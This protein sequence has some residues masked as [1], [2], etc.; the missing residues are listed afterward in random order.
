[1]K[2]HITLLLSLTLL[3][4]EASHAQTATVSGFSSVRRVSFSRPIPRPT[5]PAKLV[6]G[7]VVFSDPDDNR[8]INAGEMGCISFRVS[9]QGTGEAYVI[10]PG[11]V[12]NYS[13]VRLGEAATIASLPP[14]ES[15]VVRVSV[16]S[17]MRLD[18]RKAVFTITAAEGNGFDA[19]RQLLAVGTKSFDPPCVVVADTK[20]ETN[21]GGFS[22]S[23]GSVVRMQVL[24]QNTGLSAARGVELEFLQPAR[25]VFRLT[26]NTKVKVGDLLPG[27]QKTLEYQFMINNT[28]G[29]P[30]VNIETV[31]T[32]SLGRYG[33]R[34]SNLLA[35][36]GHLAS[37]SMI[38]VQGDYSVPE[39]ASGSLTSDVDAGIPKTS[40]VKDHVFALI[41]GNEHY[42]GQNQGVG[43]VDVPYAI[44]DA[45]SFEQYCMLTLGIP[46]ENIFFRRDATSAQMQVDIARVCRTASSFPSSGAE[47]VVYYAGH[48][49]CDNEK[50]S[51]LVPVD[52]AGT[53]VRYNGISLSKLYRQL[54]A[55]SGVRST[56]VIDACFSG[57]ARAGELFAARGIKVEPNPDVI[58]GQIVVFSATSLSQTAFPYNDKKHGMFTY[59]FLK[60]L[61]SGGGLEIKYGDMA[62]YLRQ[63]VAH[64][65]IKLNN[66]EQTPVTLVGLE[67]QNSWSG[68]VF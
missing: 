67:V 47:V 57:G 19:P 37:P 52:V 63:Q 45:A 40:R 6:I 61:Q 1:M 43:E 4:F 15:V 13:G 22:A 10:E 30:N 8:V 64:Y 35:V 16:S 65:S 50:N 48:G 5:S 24:V 17:D 62:D 44:S 29:E 18:T 66:S 36:D 27:D 46:K 21:N 11:V 49:L 34:R 23:L 51:Y 26:D 39:I 32:E 9:N 55:L 31:L 33:E 58:P 42:R 68:W 2:I 53:Q 38:E 41:I 59:F 20:F 56:V 12:V 7:D 3:A 54:G 28:F 14:G 25:D 60:K